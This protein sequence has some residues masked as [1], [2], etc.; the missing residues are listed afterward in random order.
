MNYALIKSESRYIDLFSGCG[1]LSLGLHQAGWKGVFAIEKSPDAFATLRHNLIDTKQHFDWPVWLPKKNLEID[2]VIRAY[3]EQLKALRGT[4]D[5][6]A[7]GP[8][9]QGFSMAGR[10]NENDQRNNLVESYIQFIKLVR[11]K[12]IFFENVKGFTQEFKKNKDKGKQYAEYVEE[13]LDAAGY[14]V[15][16][17]LINFG[18][19]GVPQ[20]R[21]RF[22]LVGIR[23][24][25]AGRRHAL[26]RRF[27]Y[28][29]D[30][31][32][33]AFLDTLGLRIDT[34]L[35]DAIS[36]LLHAHGT[37]ACPEPQ[38]QC[39][40]VGKYGKQA[41]SAYQELMRGTSSSNVV[42]SHRFANHKPPTVEKM[43]FII[44]N[45]PRNK[46]IDAATREKYEMK[47]HAITLLDSTAKSPT[48]TSLPDDYVHYCEPR[49]LTVREYARIQSFPDW[50]AFKGK[51]TTGGPERTT[52][53]PRYTQI[54]NAIPPLFGHQSG[55]AIKQLL[56]G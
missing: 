48:I 43:K 15:K 44:A 12:V 35:G 41:K 52:T 19:Y 9:C 14:H 27:F 47:K 25:V 45:A 3:P 20:R 30:H 11:P 6:V 26:A 32:K 55:L 53:V 5:M 8:P 38:M 28:K 23:K 33:A 18:D 42:D 13:A 56:N 39:F 54:G 17:E 37:V 46:G 31:K 7:G 4:I 10:R 22:I 1:G 34:N 24:D 21:T 51:Y 2:Q 29:I 50:Y 49:I 36:D 40:Q 16:G